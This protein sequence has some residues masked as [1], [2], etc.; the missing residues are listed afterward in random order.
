VFAAG[1]RIKSWRPA[2]GTP[3]HLNFQTIEL[4]K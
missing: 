3:Y 1:P 4:A 2:T